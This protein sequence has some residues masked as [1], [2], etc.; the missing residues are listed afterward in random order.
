M[1]AAKEAEGL[2]AAQAR[3]MRG[4]L[5]KFA[6]KFKCLI[7]MVVGPGGKIV[8]FGVPKD[9]EQAATDAEKVRVTGGTYEGRDGGGWAR[10][11]GGLIRWRASDH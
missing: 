9:G 10:A 5:P 8:Y 4:R 6:E 1:R 2:S 7:G 11:G 3:D